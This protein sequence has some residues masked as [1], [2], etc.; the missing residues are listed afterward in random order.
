MGGTEK[1][2]RFLGK[3]LQDLG[4]EVF[5]AAPSR[6]EKEYRYAHDG[7]AVY[8]YPIS[9][10]PSQ[11]E[12]RGL[13]APQYLDVFNNWLKELK[14]DIVHFHSRS[15]GCGFF[16]ASSV[17]RMNIPMVL[18]IHA[19]DFMC[20]AGTAMSWGVEPCDGKINEDRCTACLLKNRGVPL[21]WLAWLV[22]RTP[23]VLTRFLGKMKGKLG[24]LFSMRKLFLQRYKREKI[25]LGYFKR[26]IVV[27]KW[28]GEVIKLNDIPEAKVFYSPHGLSMNS[29]FHQSGNKPHDPA[30]VKIGFVGRFDHVKGIHILIKA[31]MKLPQHI[32]IELEIYG[33]ANFEEDRM[34]LKK[35]KRLSRGD[36][37]IKFCGELTEKNYT[38]VMSSFDLIAVPSIWMETGPYIILEAFQEGVPVIG[39]NLGSIPEL[40]THNLNGMLVT[41]GSVRAWSKALSWVCQHPEVLNSWASHI[42]R[43][44]NSKEVAEEMSSLYLDVLAMKDETAA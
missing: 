36:S 6:D 20:V 26:I 9:S 4:W 30:K 24:T 31:I 3:D 14:P 39:G 13:V 32:G 29:E 37:R 44:R 42:P 1:Y 27:A 34:Y 19:A 2:V 21:W 12:L 16:H 10:K 33:R 25:L 28:L 40:V 43:I 18:T 8:R 35:I 7:L 23:D 15:R 5:V 17:K 38:K 41:S 22:S 11:E